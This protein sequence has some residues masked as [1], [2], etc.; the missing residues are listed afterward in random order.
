[1]FHFVLWK[2]LKEN[3]WNYVKETA[4]TLIGRVLIDVIYLLLSYWH[5]RK[6]NRRRRIF[7]SVPKSR[8]D[9]LLDQDRGRAET[10][11]QKSRTEKP[12]VCGFHGV[13]NHGQRAHHRPASVRVWSADTF[14]LYSTNSYE[15]FPTDTTAL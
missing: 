9:N 3:E 1:M 11:P 14:Y 6:K 7:F 2:S 12:G 15:A 10:F 8:S 4:G 13:G 5:R